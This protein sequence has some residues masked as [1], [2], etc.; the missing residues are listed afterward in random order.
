MSSTLT[1]AV[2]SLGIK[3]TVPCRWD[4]GCGGRKKEGHKGVDC[5]A[6]PGETGPDLVRDITK[7]WDWLEDNSVDEINSG[8]VL[9]HLAP[10]ARVLFFN[11][12]YRVLKPGGKAFVACPHWNSCRAYGDPTHVWPPVGAFTWLYLNEDWRKREAPH[13]DIEFAAD[14]SL[15][16]DCNFD[17]VNA[18]TVHPLVQMKAQEVRDHMMT[19]ASEA[20]PDIMVTLTKA[21]RL[22]PANPCPGPDIKD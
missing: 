20:C 3:E 7:P 4:I 10:A 21:E 19:F 9:E 6:F 14:K 8:H 1:K 13:T 11:E 15:G 17:H 16:F 22:K 5:I 2:N 12:C 18:Y